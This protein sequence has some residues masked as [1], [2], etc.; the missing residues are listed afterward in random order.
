MKDS[1]KK[2]YK[3]HMK[4][5][6]KAEK[7]G[8]FL[9]LFVKEMVKRLQKKGYDIKKSDFHVAYDGWNHEDRDYRLVKMPNGSMEWITGSTIF[10]GV[11]L[12]EK[13][14]Q[15]LNAHRVYSEWQ[16]NEKSAFRCV[17]DFDGENLKE[18][19]KKVKKELKK[20]DRYADPSKAFEKKMTLDRMII[21]DNAGT[22]CRHVPRSHCV[23]PISPI[24]QPGRRY[25]SH[26][27]ERGGTWG[28]CGLDR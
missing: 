4:G 14:V 9:S 11:N 7:E 8:Y 3:E 20:R 26:C 28:H 23:G 21:A 25:D 22:H 10:L 17:M 18:F 5:Q 6:S 19:L 16:N 24:S 27:G 1:E 12:T 13:D 2:Y 15:Y